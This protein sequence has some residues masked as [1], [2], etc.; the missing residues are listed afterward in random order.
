ME[1][2]LCRRWSTAISAWRVLCQVMPGAAWHGCPLMPVQRVFQ[3]QRRCC[4]DA[5]A[6]VASG[7]LQTGRFKKPALERQPL[8]VGGQVTFREGTQRKGVFLSPA[9]LH[10]ETGAG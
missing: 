3:E 4:L 1:A 7:L 8:V 5:P 2:A 10:A 9:L 6:D